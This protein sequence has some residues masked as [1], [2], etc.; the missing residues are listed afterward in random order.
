MDSTASTRA[1]RCSTSCG[2]QI[3]NSLYEIGLSTGAGA[4]AGYVFGIINPIGGAV[5]GASSALTST[6]ALAIADKLGMDNTA[7]KIAAW[8]TTF[9]VSVGVGI[10]AATAAGFPLTV[11][12]SV[13]MIFAM[14]VT[15][16]AIRIV[17]NGAGC[18]SACAAGA[19]L[20]AK[21]HFC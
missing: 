18:L 6:I 4:L 15:T 11:L 16:V 1:D 10:F 5:F 14:F 2:A 12:G 3:F 8:V 19:G 17:T 9:I 7:F 21:E 13:G 20:A